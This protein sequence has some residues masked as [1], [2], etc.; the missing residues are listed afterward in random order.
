MGDI[1]IVERIWAFVT[2]KEPK[3]KHYGFGAGDEIRHRDCFGTRSLRLESPERSR[4][5]NAPGI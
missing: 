1:A 5:R 4:R 3:L 2:A